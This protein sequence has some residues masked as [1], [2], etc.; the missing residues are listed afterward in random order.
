MLLICK[1]LGGKWFIPHV[2]LIVYVCFWKLKMSNE[3]N[4]VQE[5]EKYECLY[6]Y[7]IAE[8]S[9]KDITDKAWERVAKKTNLSVQECEEKWRNIRSSFLRSMKYVKAVNTSENNRNVPEPIPDE[10]RSCENLA[11]EDSPSNENFNEN[12]RNDDFNSTEETNRPASL[13]KQKTIQHLSATPAS[14]SMS[15]VRCRKR[16]NIEGEQTFVNYLKAKTRKV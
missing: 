14:T 16:Y 8:Y 12:S 10:D 7:K 9:R 1:F 13:A 15:T 3:I 11:T 4:L 2:C 6:N 5:I